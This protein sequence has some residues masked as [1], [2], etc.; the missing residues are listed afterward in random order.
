MSMI[1][2][3]MTRLLLTTILN[4]ELPAEKRPQVVLEVDTL[5]TMK[6]C[7]TCDQSIMISLHA[8]VIYFIVQDTLLH[9]GR[10]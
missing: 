9:A 8:W 7:I 1:A 6:I 3:S 10:R 4:G 2:L 5:A